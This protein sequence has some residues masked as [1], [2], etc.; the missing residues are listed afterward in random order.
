[1]KKVNQIRGTEGVLE[2]PG[3]H[4]AV[5]IKVVRVHFNNKVLFKQRK[6]GSD[7]VSKW[8]SGRGVYYEVEETVHAKALRWNNVRHV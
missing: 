2:E 8:L 4:T 3:G 5:F 7:G 1:M 6:K